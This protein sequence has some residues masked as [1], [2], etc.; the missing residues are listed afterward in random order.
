M[1]LQAPLLNLTTSEPRHVADGHYVSL[2]HAPVENRGD[3]DS[4][5]MAP[6]LFP[7]SPDPAA[8]DEGNTD[9]A[10]TVT[11]VAL[12]TNITLFSAALAACIMAGNPLV[13]IAAVLDSFS[14][15]CITTLLSRVTYKINHFDPHEYP[16]GRNALEPVIVL[17]FAAAASTIAIFVIKSG[18]ED[19]I[20]MYETSGNPN[21]EVVPLPSYNCSIAP[22]S[23][24]P[25]PSSAGGRH[26]AGSQATNGIT[27]SLPVIIC[28]GISVVGNILGFIYCLHAY[29]KSRSQVAKTLMMDF[30][31]DC[32]TYIFAVSMVVMVS[33][34]PDAPIRWLSPAGGILISLLIV[35][36]WFDEG[37]EQATKLSGVVPEDEGRV[38]EILDM[39]RREVAQNSVP[40]HVP[41]DDASQASSSV[42][43][44]AH[45]QKLLVYHGGTDLI[46][47]VE[48][49][50]PGHHLMDTARVAG[51]MA[52]LRA[53]VEMEEDVER[54]FVTLCAA[55]A[56]SEHN[57][58][59]GRVMVNHTAL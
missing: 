39:C 7:V 50:L 14:D 8:I 43:F 17:A 29:L 31:N 47:E 54:C 58:R 42:V 16:R 35:K 38:P 52:R 1:S 18:A 13:L 21:V 57:G 6:L 44:A 40:G 9:T 33:K 10:D 3:S 45:I 12:G 25:T 15:L 48:L 27:L 20:T 19:L 4:E 24:S 11:R 34:F 5:G 26:Q 30:R 55:A 46:V 49:A 59:P 51:C 32:A 36:T 41:T 22:A 2:S 53:R 37:C 28:F 23:S 56:V